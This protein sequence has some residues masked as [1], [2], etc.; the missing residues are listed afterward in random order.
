MEA[1]SARRAAFR[2]PAM[3]FWST[4]TA[5]DT[6]SDVSA[7]LATAEVSLLGTV[8]RQNRVSTSLS[9]PKARI[10]FNT[11]GKKHTRKTMI[12]LGS[13]PNPSHE[14]KSGANAI[15]GVISMLTKNG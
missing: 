12:T 11:M 6:S 9:G 1:A 2:F 8:A 7:I 10:A 5:P 15:F 14:M 4:S 13:S 3:M